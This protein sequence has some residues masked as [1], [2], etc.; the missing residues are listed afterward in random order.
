MVNFITKGNFF[1]SNFSQIIKQKSHK[2]YFYFIKVI[3]KF[4]GGDGEI[5]Y[6]DFFNNGEQKLLATASTD[7]LI[8]IWDLESGE[9]LFTLK[10][11]TKSV[12]CV[13]FID[14]NNLLSGSADKTV[15][16]WNFRNSNSSIVFILYYFYL[17]YFFFFN[18]IYYLL[19]LLFYYLFYLLFIND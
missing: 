3:K 10:G 15:Q 7:K 18:F 13:T 1:F 6:I 4:K 12:S 11:H 16:L 2:I 8:K 14:E 17:N 19:R 5:L 9:L